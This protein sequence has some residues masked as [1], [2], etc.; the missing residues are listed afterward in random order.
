MLTGRVASEHQVLQN[1]FIAGTIEIP[2][3]FDYLAHDG[4]TSA[5]FASKRKLSYFAQD[6]SSVAQLNVENLAELVRKSLDAIESTNPDFV[7]LHFNE[8]DNS[9]HENGSWISLRSVG[10]TTGGTVRNLRTYL[11]VAALAAPSA[12]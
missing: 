9:G 4:L 3:V 2:T 6:T 5:F 10:A 7:F 8:P 1:T 11:R 12:L